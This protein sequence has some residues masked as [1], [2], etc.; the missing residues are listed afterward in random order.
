MRLD[1]FL[2]QEIY[3]CCSKGG[4]QEGEG[5]GGEVS[6]GGY[7][8]GGGGGGYKRSRK[9]NVGIV[10]V[11]LLMYTSVAFIIFLGGKDIE[12][13]TLKGLPR[14]HIYRYSFSARCKERLLIAMSV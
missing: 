11:R 9:I 7:V 1:Y 2:L 3:Q 14:I 4:K 10:V 6:I 5:G 12:G 13:D 8:G